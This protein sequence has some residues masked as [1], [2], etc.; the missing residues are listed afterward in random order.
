M[1]NL[2]NGF[3]KKNLLGKRFLMA[4][5]TM[6]VNA[7]MFIGGLM[8]TA[9]SLFVAALPFIAIGV[10]II[11]A[12]VGLVMAFNYMYENVEWF[13]NGIDWIAE[14]RRQKWAAVNGIVLKLGGI[15]VFSYISEQSSPWAY[16]FYA[17]SK[18]QK[19]L[20]KNQLIDAGHIIFPWP[21]LPDKILTGDDQGNALKRWYWLLCVS[22]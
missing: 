20:I 8:M 11:G 21:V 2:L 6:L 18:S 16:P 15:P 7:L 10:L 1:R 13:R 9:A 22:L 5:A 4:S 3:L 14:K 17:K 19:E 12:I